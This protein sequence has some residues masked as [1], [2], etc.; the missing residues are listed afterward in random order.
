MQTSQLIESP[1]NNR[2]RPDQQ[3]RKHFDSPILLQLDPKILPRSRIP[4]NQLESFMHEAEV[5]V[6]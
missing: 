2:W 5:A 6:E 1:S 4:A 3:L